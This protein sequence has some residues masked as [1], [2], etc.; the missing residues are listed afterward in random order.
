MFTRQQIIIPL[1]VDDMSECYKSFILV[2][3]PNRKVH[4][5]LD[6]ARLNYVLK[7]PKYMGHV[8]ND[9]FP[10]GNACT[11]LNTHRHKLG[12]AQPITEE[13]I[14]IHN[15]ICMSVWKIILTHAAGNIF[16]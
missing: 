2:P 5:Y 8:V 10:K 15:H 16:Q 9:V 4:L 11:I 13:K 7:R 12:V 14:F 1:G 3:K 6:P